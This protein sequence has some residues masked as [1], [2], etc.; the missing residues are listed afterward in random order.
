M[1]C[2]G[3]HTASSTWQWSK[4]RLTGGRPLAVT[5]LTST[6][7]RRQIVCAASYS[8]RYR[9]LSKTTRLTGSVILLS[10]FSRIS[11]QSPRNAQV[12][13]FKPIIVFCH[14]IWR[15]RFAFCWRLLKAGRVAQYNWWSLSTRLP[16]QPAIDRS[17]C[18]PPYLDGRNF[19]PKP[20]GL[21]EARPL[22]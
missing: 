20:T 15:F 9:C 6:G 7:N 1:T 11:T 3:S 12:A 10:V 19:H 4:R 21:P 8:Y 13:D 18:V 17:T 2:F 14:C 5:S 22:V 16:S